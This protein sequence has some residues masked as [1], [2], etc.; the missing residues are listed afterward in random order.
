MSKTDTHKP[1]THKHRNI[2]RK[3][4]TKFLFLNRIHFSVQRS[5]TQV[6]HV[7]LYIESIHILDTAFVLLRQDIA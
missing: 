4:R 6:E 3:L 1:H 7:R 2:D 5:V